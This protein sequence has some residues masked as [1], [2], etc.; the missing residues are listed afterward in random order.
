MVALERRLRGLHRRLLLLKLRRVLLGILHRARTVVGQVLVARRLLLRE[1]QVGLRL[2]H[3]RLALG[4]LGLL[5][6][7]LGL[8][9]LNAGLRTGHLRLGLGKCEAVIAIVD[10]GDHGAGG[11][12]RVVGDRNGGGV[13][14]HLGRNGELAR[15][16]ESVVGR[17][18]VPGIVPVEISP[19]PLFHIRKEC[20]ELAGV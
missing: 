3:L 2:P 4:H 6:A 16:D 14:R 19:I 13:A 9:V 17:L 15:R 1:G 5:H 10:A 8:D 7:D 12:M 20:G 18:E 11:D